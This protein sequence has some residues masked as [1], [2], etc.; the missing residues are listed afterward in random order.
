MIKF[1]ISSESMWHEINELHGESG[2]VYILRCGV[3]TPIPVN[4]LLASDEEGTLYI[5]KANSFLNRVAELKK[6]ISPQYK[7]GSHE[8]GTR[9]KSH[10]GIYKVYPYEELY[11][12]LVESD[13]PRTTESNLL[14]NYEKKFGELPP[15]NRVS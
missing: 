5:G 11:I 14:Q 3:E 9:Y 10:S 8:C 7:S 15:L 12:N 2:G 1:K 13:D 6:S 4:R